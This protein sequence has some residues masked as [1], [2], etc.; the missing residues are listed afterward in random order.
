MDKKAVQETAKR[1]LAYNQKPKDPK[2]PK[3]PTK[4]DVA[5]GD[6]KEDCEV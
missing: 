6:D 3:Y 4:T 2:D 5:K 1:K